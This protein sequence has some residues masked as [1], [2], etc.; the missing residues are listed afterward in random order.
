MFSIPVDINYYLPF[1]IKGFG[2]AL[3]LHAQ[4]TLGVPTDMGTEDTGG[5]KA[6]SEFINVGFFV[7]TPLVF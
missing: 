1:N 4:E 6:T 3:N 7:T 5:G 2:I